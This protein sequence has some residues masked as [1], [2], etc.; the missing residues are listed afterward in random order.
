M[1]I[2][3]KLESVDCVW[4]KGAHNAFTDL[5]L[6][7]GYW[8]CAFRQAQH[9]MSLDGQ[10]VILCRQNDQAWVKSAEISWAGGDLRDPK[11]VVT[12][13]GQLVLMAG[14][15]WAVPTSPSSVLCSV[16]WQLKKG[17][18]SD[19][20]VTDQDEGTWR[21][22]GSAN[23]NHIFSIGYAGKD[24]DGC[25]YLSEDGKYWQPHLKPFFPNPDCFSNEASLVFAPDATGYCLLRRD[26]EE[27][28]G[29]FGQAKPP[30]QV[31][32]WQP[33]SVRIG[34]PKL[35]Q[36]SSGELIAAFRVFEEK[37]PKVMIY[38]IETE[39]ARL[40]HLIT[41]PSEGDCSYPGLVE[42]DEHLWVSYYSSHEGK[43]AIYLAK[44]SR[45]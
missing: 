18:V 43:A 23:P 30:Y 2:G 34:G 13:Q 9:H 38:E 6:F 15:R 4:D 31:W 1:T 32:Q 29:L 3:L 7:D 40:N 17:A 16:T 20:F 45:T 12:P 10:I 14:V 27:C 25:L 21:W 24:M 11:F 22:S 28:P 33:L 37:Q 19:P 42:K 36:L 41:L 8:Y 5:I 35:I 39:S 26:G 44:L